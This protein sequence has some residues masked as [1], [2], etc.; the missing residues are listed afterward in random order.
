VR[1]QDGERNSRRRDLGVVQGMETAVDRG[2][3]VCGADRR[4][5]DHIPDAGLPCSPQGVRVVIGRQWPIRGKEECCVDP[6]ER[7]FQRPGPL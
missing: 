4:Q 6:V 3:V 5:A 1:L 7:A 2:G